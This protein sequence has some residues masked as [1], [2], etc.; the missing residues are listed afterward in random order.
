MNFES[1]G[2]LRCWERHMSEMRF[3]RK[4][5]DTLISGVNLSGF[6]ID[7]IG[8]MPLVTPSFLRNDRFIH[9]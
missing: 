5:G 1:L 2:L 7:S 4:S 9:P 3:E 6:N 8:I